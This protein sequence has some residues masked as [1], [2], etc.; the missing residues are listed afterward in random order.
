MRIDNKR[1]GFSLFFV[2]MYAM[3]VKRLIFFV[4]HWTL[5]IPQLGIPLVGLLLT[6]LAIELGL[7]KTTT[8][9]PPIV[10]G[11]SIYNNPV[12]TVIGDDALT[13]LYVP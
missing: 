5:M 9:E 4:R 10:L 8:A 2:Q 7:A 12:A 3:F 1:S 6:L 11:L 13:A